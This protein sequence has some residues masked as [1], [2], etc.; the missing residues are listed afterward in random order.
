MPKIPLL[1]NPSPAGAFGR[2]CCGP[3]GSNPLLNRSRGDSVCGR[4]PPVCSLR[5][6]CAP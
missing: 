1:N 4:K 3:A 2:R 6:A 5:P